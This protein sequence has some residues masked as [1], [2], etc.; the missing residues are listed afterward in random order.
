L[1]LSPGSILWVVKHSLS[2][3]E[4]APLWPFHLDCRSEVENR[5]PSARGE[6]HAIHSY[7]QVSVMMRN[8][9]GVL[10]HKRITSCCLVILAV[11]SAVARSC[12]TAVVFRHV[13][14]INATGNPLQPDMTVVIEGQR[15]TAV[16]KD[17]SAQIPKDARI[18]EARGKYL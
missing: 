8:L 17:A 15:I 12:N 10:M 14:V 7:H 2:S 3:L 18:I 5:L 6:Q 16:G 4:P 11:S 1:P 9:R 13:N